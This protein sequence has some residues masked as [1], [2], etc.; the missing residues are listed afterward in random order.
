VGPIFLFFCL[1]R[2]T[3]P[4]EWHLVRSSAIKYRAI[5]LAKHYK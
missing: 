1:A 3:E 5:V 4:L 2:K